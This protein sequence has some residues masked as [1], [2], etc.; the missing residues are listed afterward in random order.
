[1]RHLRAVVITALPVEYTAVRQHLNDCR[2]Q[3]TPQGTVYEQGQF[4]SPTAVWDI[5][6]A[7]IGAGNNGAAFEVERAISNFTPNCVFFVGVAGGIK[8]VDV[9]DVVAAEKIYGYESGKDRAGRFLPR[10]TVGE[11]TYR[12]VQ[13]ARAEA[14]RSAWAQWRGDAGQ[15]PRV[16]V[17]AIAA[18]EKVVADARSTTAEFIRELYSDAIAVEM[19]GKGFLE[20]ARTNPGVEALVI[21]G[22]SDL[23]SN[24]SEGDERGRQALA[25]GNAAAFLC[26]VLDGLGRGQVEEI[27]EIVQ[28]ERK[29]QTF[30][31]DVSSY[32][33]DL[34]ITDAT[35]KYVK[36]TK[37]S[38][39]A[40][41]TQGV[42]SYADHFFADGKIEE[43]W[44]NPG[45]VEYVITHGSRVLV[46]T[47]FD[48]MLHA[49]AVLNR[50]FGCTFVDC[51]P[52]TEEFWICTPPSPTDDIEVCI[53][54]PATRRCTAV[55]AFAI[56]GAGVS[57]ERPSLLRTT[58][59]TSPFDTVL[60][61]IRKPTL[62][63]QYTLAWTW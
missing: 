40:V 48:K 13:R 60:C 52:S 53:K 19:E 15:L 42:R 37:S 58:P 47:R 31:F 36:Y 50:R 54:F 18:G 4:T 41:R 56:D 23:L 49:G 1:M 17:G 6:L 27:P 39:S 44:S 38:V 8:D 5:F 24:K 32:R 26:A 22:V 55:R 63:S 30:N 16:F 57:E 21:R 61:Q 46:L 7:E 43:I 33:V 29:V 59:P 51:F 11:S 62:D 20:A 9:G 12:M 28:F 10:P 2:E 25:S 35:G 3:V 45:H 34:E 14:K